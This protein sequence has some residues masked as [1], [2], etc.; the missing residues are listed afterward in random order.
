MTS[1]PLSQDD[2][3]LAVPQNLPVA[4]HVQEA[5]LTS[6]TEGRSREDTR[7][8][9]EVV[10]KIE[11]GLMDSSR[12]VFAGLGLKRSRSG[13]GQGAGAQRLARPI[14][15]RRSSS[16]GSV[17]GKTMKRE[18]CLVQRR[19]PLKLPHFRSFNVPAWFVREQRIRR[20]EASNR[21]PSGNLPPIPI[22]PAS[23]LYS[24]GPWASHSWPC[25]SRLIAQSL[26]GPCGIVPPLTPPEDLDP[27]KW[28]LPLQ[29]EPDQGV[30]TESDVERDRAQSPPHSQPRPSSTSRPSE[31]RMPERSD[32][33]QD[34]PSHSNWLGRA[35]LHLCSVVQDGGSQQQL[36]MVVQTL[37]SQAKSSEFQPVFEIVV[38]AVQGRFTFPPYITITHAVSQVISM[39]EVPASPPA[40][41]NASYSSD[42]YFQDQ[43]IFTHAAVVP[44]YHS[45]SP[46]SANIGPRPTNIIAAPSS[47]QISILERYIP[48]TTGQEVT[49][50]FTLSRRSYL[51]DRLLELSSNNGS[52]LLIYPTKVGGVAFANKY[53]GPVIEPF[54]RQFILLNGLYTDVA[55][56][57][58]RMAAVANMKTFEETRELIAAMCEALAQRAPSRGIPNRYEIVHAETAEV[59]LDRALWRDWYIE[60]EQ[61]RLRQHLVD[62]H[63][64]GGRMPSRT[65]H[66]EVTPGML[67]R[68]VVEGI[69]Q[70]R[71]S[72]GNV[73][74]EVGV[75]VIR[76]TIV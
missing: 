16:L 25:P 52:L 26:N 21:S 36:Q 15:R 47:I 38:E 75:F 45:Q 70:S 30:H 56:Q 4:L 71:E 28:D 76:R 68:E 61:P 50:F 42:D 10:E 24:L 62:Y 1:Q 13:D 54:L 6:P 9:I 34:E 33:G 69:R 59:S 18:D 46:S 31:I 44:A 19:P 40:T 8:V 74:I 39:D 37:P 51:A 14:I 53:I 41:P 60:Q 72:A 22:P 48:P 23:R 27:F 5:S 57:L 55:M 49:D 12:S 7:G 11:H 66:V 43:T 67:A 65:G 29:T 3:V 35:C 17:E 32:I 58:G 64:A 73:G 2:E 63:K 20:L